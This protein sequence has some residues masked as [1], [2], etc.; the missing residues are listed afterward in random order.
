M[1]FVLIILIVIV[2]IILTNWPKPANQTKFRIEQTKDRGANPIYAVLE[3]QPDKVVIDN[4]EYI[5]YENIE[6]A[7]V[8]SSVHEIRIVNALIAGGKR[9]RQGRVYRLH[10]YYKSRFG[11][12]N[13]LFF[14]SLRAHELRQYKVIADKINFKIG[15]KEP[16]KI[17]EMRE[18]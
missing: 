15:Y 16:E 6:K 13:S 5:L 2:V 3:L 7:Y 10:I 11:S 8:E 18:L 14:G 4:S 12:S 1:E 9:Y 17:D